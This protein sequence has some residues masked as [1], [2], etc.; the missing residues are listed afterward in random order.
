ML[1][2]LSSSNVP[3]N[4]TNTEN[5]VD[6]DALADFEYSVITDPNDQS[7]DVTFEER[8]MEVEPDQTPHD[9][10]NGTVKRNAK[11]QLSSDSSDSEIQSELKRERIADN[12]P[13]ASFKRELSDDTDN[14]EGD[15]K[16]GRPGQIK[17]GL[18][19][20]SLSSPERKREKCDPSEL[21]DEWEC[22]CEN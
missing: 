14:E 4:N 19:D 16:R 9:V 3:Q 11:R 12:V 21:S 5:Q 8:I 13:S 18:S 20:S 2:T 10:V 1:P 22:D 6:S 15:Y 7:I 17:R